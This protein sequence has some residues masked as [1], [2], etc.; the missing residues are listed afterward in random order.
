MPH[1]PITHVT[2]AASSTA[3]FW[4]QGRADGTHTTMPRRQLML[5]IAQT[6]VAAAWLRTAEE[7]LDA[8]RS[9]SLACAEPTNA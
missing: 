5:G 4:D 2:P 7:W 3:T 9:L 8:W 6:G 1:A